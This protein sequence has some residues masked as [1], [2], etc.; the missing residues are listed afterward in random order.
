MA[1]T[2]FI[3]GTGSP[4]GNELKFCRQVNSPLSGSCNTSEHLRW[5]DSGVHGTDDYGFSGLPGGSRG[6]NGTFEGV[7]QTGYWWSSAEQYSSSAWLR[8]VNYGF[9][10]ISMYTFYKLNGFLVRCLRD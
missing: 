7:G 6:S 3:G 5:N 9:D 10:D 4:H 8:Y 1:L 2:D